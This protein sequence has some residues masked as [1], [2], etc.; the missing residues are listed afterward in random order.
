MVMGEQGG[1]IRVIRHFAL[2]IMILALLVLPFEQHGSP[3]QIVAV[4]VL[5]I[6]AVTLAATFLIRPK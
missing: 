3:E 4:M 5:I 2:V 6:N 1:F